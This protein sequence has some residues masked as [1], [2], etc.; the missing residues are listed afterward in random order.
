MAAH[1]THTCTQTH[2]TT[3]SI[4]IPN[5]SSEPPR[6]QLAQNP[7]PDN[8]AL[9]LRTTFEENFHNSFHAMDRIV[10][11]PPPQHALA[12]EFHR[13]LVARES[14]ILGVRTRDPRPGD[15]AVVVEV[16]GEDVT[17]LREDEV[18][19]RVAAEVGDG[20][21]DAVV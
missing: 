2:I 5:N 21:E 12:L 13:I 19:V 10:P 14:H 16:L 18:R 1:P 9:L 8:L 6:L 4:L 11:I 3:L 7:R 20:V 15:F 17:G